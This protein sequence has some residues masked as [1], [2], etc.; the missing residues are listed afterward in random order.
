MAPVK[1]APGGS[2]AGAAPCRGSTGRATGVLS[3][4]R[5]GGGSKAGAAPRCSIAGGPGGVVSGA[6]TGGGGISRAKLLEHSGGLSGNT[7]HRH[8]W[9]IGASQADDPAPDPRSPQVQLATSGEK[10]TLPPLAQAAVHQ[11][12]PATPWDTGSV[13]PPPGVLDP[14][15]SG[16]ARPTGCVAPFSGAAE[17][18]RDRDTP[19]AF[20]GESFSG[21][22]KL[23]S[24]RQLSST[25]CRF[26]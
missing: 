10:M 16:P 8:I 3:G 14:E 13:K 2:E 17:F 12:P 6:G 1:P 15:G 26:P 23:A 9:T 18:K 4:T 22:C 20:P 5:T 24:S 19:P 25:N 21:P 7:V 11:L